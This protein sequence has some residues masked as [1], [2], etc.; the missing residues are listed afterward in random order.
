MYT[1]DIQ[2]HVFT[3]TGTWVSS[4]RYQLPDGSSFP[5]MYRAIL[6]HSVHTLGKKSLPSDQ[7]VTYRIVFYYYGNVHY[8]TPDF[9]L[10]NLVDYPHILMT[11]WGITKPNEQI[12]IAI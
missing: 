12:H 1:T 10:Q 5:N 3:T 2:Y 9:K 7:N 4:S 6:A 8:I 11:S